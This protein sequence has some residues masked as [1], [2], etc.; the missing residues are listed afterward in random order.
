MCVHLVLGASSG[1]IGKCFEMLCVLMECSCV[2]ARAGL[3][4]NCS[5]FWSVD[6]FLNWSV[7]SLRS[8]TELGNRRLR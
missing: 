2:C 4:R 6:E 7:F 5:F 8:I 1:K 3:K